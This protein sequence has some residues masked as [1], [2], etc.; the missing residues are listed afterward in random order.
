MGLEIALLVF[1]S[2]V[3]ISCPCALGLAIPTAIMVGTGKGA[4]NGILMKGGDS[5]EAIH[6]VNTIIFDKTGTLTVGRPK[7][8]AII[9]EKQILGNG[10]QEKEILFYAG[11]AEMG[12]EHPLAQ[13]IIE[14]ANQRGITLESPDEFEAIPGEGI[15]TVIKNTSLIFS[16]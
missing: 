9:S 3:V 8:T 4:E 6:N 1:T 5:L 7:V 15:S 10:L 13:A 2:V 12:S 14:E 11:S 16:N